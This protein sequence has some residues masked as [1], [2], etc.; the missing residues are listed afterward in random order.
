MASP[1]GHPGYLLFRSAFPVPP[2]DQCSSIG[3]LSGGVTEGQCLGFVGAN[4]DMY[5]CMYICISQGD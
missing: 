1:Q 5:V 3:N 4:A 2:P